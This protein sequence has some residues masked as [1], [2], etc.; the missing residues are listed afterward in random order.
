MNVNRSLFYAMVA[1][2]ILMLMGLV[3]LWKPASAPLPRMAGA[4]VALPTA[5]QSDFTALVQEPDS[6]A[7]AA[8]P[9]PEKEENAAGRIYGRPV[10]DRQGKTPIALY[11]SAQFSN[12]ADADPQK[13]FAVLP[14]FSIA[15]APAAGAVSTAYGNGSRS[16][17]S[18]APPA[19]VSSGAPS[20]YAGSESNRA[21][22]VR[23]IWSSFA[24]MQTR[25]EQQAL[26]RRLQNFSSGMDRAIASALL[27]KS[28]RE[29]NIEKYLSRARGE[30]PAMDNAVYAAD[31]RA[32]GGPAEEVVR[33]LAAQSAGIVRDVGASYGAAAASR[34]ENIM[35]NYQQEMAQTLNAPGDPQEKQIQAQAVNNKYNRQLQQLNNEES[36]NKMEM[37]MRAENEQYLQ[38]IEQ[39]YGGKTSSA[40][41]PVLDEYVGKRM[42]VWRT[43][44]NAAVAKE[45][46]LALEEE[47]Q[48]S[49]EQIVQSTAPESGPSTLTQVRN[50]VLKEKILK[51]AQQEE[52]GERVSQV[53]R[54][55]PQSLEKEETAWKKES[56]ALVAQIGQQFGPEA[57]SE[58]QLIVDTLP[59]YRRRIRQQAQEEGWSVAEVNRLDM[60][61]TE[62]VNEA[63]QDLSIRQ[64]QAKYDAGNEARIEAAMAQMPGLSEDARSAWV[65][66]ARPFMEKYNG[67]RAGLLKTVR[68]NEEYQNALRDIAAQEER[69]L[70]AIEIPAAS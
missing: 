5:S 61:A 54:Q 23:R 7:L 49:L 67:A 35:K 47:Q 26:A 10:A 66:K 17:P 22:D 37:Q 58:A 8:R 70:Q 65:Q 24:P 36:L 14:P 56:A 16:Y 9:L 50:D 34:A 60:E 18:Y 4:D 11:P 44:Q 42:E 32:A 1:F 68:S 59:A 39:T 6:V 41:R 63:L 55:D 28:K 25:R 40:M 64:T 62:K 31:A 19:P 45:K 57:A 27:P 15:G 21:E 33:R 52:S 69:E 48:N 30:A 53:F 46:L 43:P 20:A 29:Q 3:L 2:I 51:E 12:S 38:K 13:P